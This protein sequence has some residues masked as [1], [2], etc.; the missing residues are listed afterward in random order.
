LRDERREAR[1]EAAVISDAGLRRRKL[2]TITPVTCNDDQRRCEHTR[3]ITQQAQR[4]YPKYDGTAKAAANNV[5]P[6]VILTRLV[7]GRRRQ[8][9]ARNGDVTKVAC[10]RTSSEWERSR[11]G[12]HT[13]E[14]KLTDAALRLTGAI[15]ERTVRA[16]GALTLRV[17][18][19]LIAV[20]ALAAVTGVATLIDT[21]A[22]GVV[23]ACVVQA[24][25]TALAHFV[26]R[27]VGAVARHSSAPLG[28]RWKRPKTTQRKGDKTQTRS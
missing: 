5:P 21:H 1:I 16:V 27:A 10:K 6:G 12:R 22:I 26:T 13:A 14:H 15:T 2:H 4:Q 9:T 8:L 23:T 20:L 7:R 3:R 17:Q 11:A 24:R 19:A 18:N 25:R 28:Y